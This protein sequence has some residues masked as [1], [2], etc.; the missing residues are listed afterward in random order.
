MQS[1]QLAQDALQKY[2]AIGKDLHKRR[3]YDGKFE[4]ISLHYQQEKKKK[5]K[6]VLENEKEYRI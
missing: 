5:K 1:H 3:R 2:A 6:V 4:C